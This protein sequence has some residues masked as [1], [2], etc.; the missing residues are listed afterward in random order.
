MRRRW[1][2][3]SCMSKR[4]GANGPKLDTWGEPLPW[5]KFLGHSFRFCKSVLAS[6]KPTSRCCSH[7]TAA[8][9]P[10]DFISANPSVSSSML[11][12][13]LCSGRFPVERSLLR[14]VHFEF[15]LNR[16]A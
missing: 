2:Q 14:M 4:G 15:G 7:E 9:R 3:R 11:G 10:S 13:L 8:N 12:A 1:Q 5:H 16:L 6:S